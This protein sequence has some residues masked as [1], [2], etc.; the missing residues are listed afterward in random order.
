MLFDPG[1]LE[2][3]LIVMFYI[4]GTMTLVHVSVEQKTHESGAEFRASVI[5]GNGLQPSHL[6]PK[7]KIMSCKQVLKVW[8]ANRQI[9]L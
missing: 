2:S 5:Q 8:A 7:A 1:A 9:I 6:G 3:N 4:R